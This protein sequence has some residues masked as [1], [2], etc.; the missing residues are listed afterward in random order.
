[1]QQAV[2][3]VVAKAETQARFIAMAADPVANTPAEFSRFLASE[4]HRYGR[5]IRD[6]EIKEE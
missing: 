2:A 3:R 5:L 6:A 4:Y 1:M